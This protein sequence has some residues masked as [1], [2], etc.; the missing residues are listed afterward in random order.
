M[1]KDKGVHHRLN[2]CEKAGPDCGS[3]LGESEENGL[4]P[5][6]E[7][8]SHNYQV[9]SMLL[10]KTICPHFRNLQRNLGRAKLSKA[11][12]SQGIQ[13][14]GISVLIDLLHG[15]RLQVFGTSLSI[16]GRKRHD[17]HRQ[18]TNSTV[19]YFHECQKLAIPAEN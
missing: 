19:L 15:S 10:F 1:V 14:L 11:L 9:Q 12:Q 16:Y 8:C 13:F 6:P 3:G 17:I 4:V 2:A 5:Y 7:L 18:C